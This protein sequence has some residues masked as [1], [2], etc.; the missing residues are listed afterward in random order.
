LAEYEQL[1]HLV[2]ADEQLFTQH[3]FE[4]G[5]VASA[6]VAYDDAPAEIVGFA[7][8]FRTFST[9]LGRP[10]IWLEDLFVRPAARRRGHA[11]AL[12]R[13]LRASTDG[14]V[15]WAVLD[16]SEDAQ[17]FYRGLGANPLDEWTTWRWDPAGE[18]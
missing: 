4:P 7:L 11:S 8:W 1:S 15:E 13:A 12:L 3:L 9:F 17:R 6:L 2:V 14:R 10:G 18:V 16:W 5:H